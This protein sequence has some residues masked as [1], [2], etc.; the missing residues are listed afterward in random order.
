MVKY[1][2]VLEQYS[3]KIAHR[4]TAYKELCNLIGGPNA[5]RAISAYNSAKNGSPVVGLDSGFAY[6]T[7]G[8]KSFKFS[9]GIEFRTAPIGNY[10]IDYC[11]ANLENVGRVRDLVVV[12]SL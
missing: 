9:K 2:N 12:A 7:N 6:V 1:S 4:A 11:G 8:S 5:T 10:Y 3:K